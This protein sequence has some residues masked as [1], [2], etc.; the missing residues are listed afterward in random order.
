M[1]VLPILLV[2][3]IVNPLEQIVLECLL[4]LIVCSWGIVL[5]AGPLKSIRATSA[6]SKMYTAHTTHHTHTL[7]HHTTHYAKYSQGA[8]ANLEVISPSAFDISVSLKSDM[9]SHLL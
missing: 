3:C 7:H 9:V 6:F 1:Y 8:F 4:S 5:A 2:L